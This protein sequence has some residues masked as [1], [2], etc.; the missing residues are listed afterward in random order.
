METASLNRKIWI[1]AYYKVSK[2]QGWKPKSGKREVTV[3]HTISTSPGAEAASVIGP[4]GVASSAS[5]MNASISL[6]SSAAVLGFLGARA[7]RGACRL[8]MGPGP[9]LMVL[10]LLKEIDDRIRSKT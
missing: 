1:H 2:D 6:S 7:A 10:R 4:T 5:P 9:E 3:L 8:R